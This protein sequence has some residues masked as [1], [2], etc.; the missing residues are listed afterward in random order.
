MHPEAGFVHSQDNQTHSSLKAIS[1]K[2]QGSNYFQCLLEAIKAL[3][4]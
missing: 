4:N 1:L 3:I 2:L